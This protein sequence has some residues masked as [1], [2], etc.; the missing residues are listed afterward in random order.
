MNQQQKDLCADLVAIDTSHTKGRDGRETD[1]SSRDAVELI[2]DRCEAAGFRVELFP[3][4]LEGHL[5]RVNIVATKGKGK[6]ALALSGHYDTM[7]TDPTEW[8]SDPFSLEARKGKVYGLGACDMKLFL[9]TAIV[10]GSRIGEDELQQ[11]FALYFTNDEEIGCI[12]A[13]RLVTFPSFQIADSIII[14]EPTEMR[15]VVGHK[16]YIFFSIKATNQPDTHIRPGK[17]AK[18]IHHSSDDSKV[19]NILMGVLPQAIADLAEFRKVLKGEQD[20]RFDPPYAT[21]NLGVIRLPAGA[22]K[23]IIPTEFTLEA[24]MRP[25][26]GMDPDMLLRGLVSQMAATATKVHSPITNE[27]VVIEARELRLPSLPMLTEPASQVVLT[28]RKV[29]LDNGL[30]DGLNYVSYNTEGGIF[31]S[32]GAQTIILGPG[33]I[34]QAHYKDEFVNEDYLDN[35]VVDFYESA[36]RHICC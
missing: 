20:T 7:P 34:K 4:Q 31:N 36:I 24:D 28:A 8:K 13:R 16:G 5:E 30:P 25:I 29:A 3:Y 17:A 35:W 23:S 6:P 9:A 11:P 19:G 33:C 26:P 10:A 2:T 22:S 32:H 15:I 21:L 27:Q 14:G 18:M 12:G 1:N